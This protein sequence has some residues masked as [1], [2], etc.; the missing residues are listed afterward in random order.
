LD[1]TYADSREG[2]F[3]RLLVDT[4]E[5]FDSEGFATACFEYDRIS[6]LDPWKTSLLVKV[7]RSIEGG[8]M[9]GGA[10]DEDDIDLT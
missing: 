7:K 1:Y 8:G 5:G 6:K 4:V 10:D 9:G 2:K 3:S